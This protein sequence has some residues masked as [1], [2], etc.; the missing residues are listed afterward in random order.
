MNANRKTSPRCEVIDLNQYRTCKNNAAARAK[1]VEGGKYMDAL[2][3]G[4]YPSNP[5]CVGEYWQN[6]V[7][8][9]QGDAACRRQGGAA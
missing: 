4:M 6:G 5:N 3:L 1:A 9:Y 2:T 8:V 7:M